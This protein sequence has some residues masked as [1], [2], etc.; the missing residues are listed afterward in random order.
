M[1]AEFRVK[2]SE[3]AILLNFSHATNTTSPRD[4]LIHEDI[5]FN[6]SQSFDPDFSN[7]SA[8]GAAA[9]NTSVVNI[10]FSCNGI[11]CDVPAI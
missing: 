1:V 5:I 9:R 2:S 10:T 4:V 11:A 6:A 8:S 7:S 3:I